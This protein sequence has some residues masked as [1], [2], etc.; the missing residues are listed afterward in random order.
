MADISINELDEVTS[1]SATDY[2]ATTVDIGGGVLVTKKIKY[3]NL[4]ASNVERV[5]GLVIQPNVVY[6]NRPQIVMIR[7]DAALT[8]SRIL[9]RCSTTAHELECTMKYA[10][11]SILFQNPVTIAVCDTTNG[12][13]LITSGFTN[14]SVPSGKIIYLLFDAEPNAAIKDFY[15]EVFYSY[16]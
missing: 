5:R 10:D 16:N 6:N 8:I 2:L 13:K 14:A 3:S 9:I 7:A 4:I 15:I 11:S 1:A 12:Y